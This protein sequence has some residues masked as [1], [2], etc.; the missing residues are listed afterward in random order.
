[1]DLSIVTKAGLTKQEFAKLMK[2]SRTTVHNWFGGAGVHVQ[3]SER[4]D[5]ALAVIARAV[6]AGDLPLP[7]GVVRAQRAAKIAAAIRKNAKPPQG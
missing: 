5:K 6:E 2:V 3:V 1:M 4:L 7:Y